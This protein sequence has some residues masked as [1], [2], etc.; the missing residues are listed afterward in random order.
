MNYKYETSLNF[1]ILVTCRYPTNSVPL[2]I[3]FK[4]RQVAV[5]VSTCCHVPYGSGPHL[6]AEISSGAALCLMT[7]NLT[8]RLRW[9]PALP[10]A[11]RLCTSPPS[12]GGLQRCHMSYCSGPHLPT[13]V[14]FDAATCPMAP[15]LASLLRWALT[16]P[17]VLRLPVGC[18]PQ[19]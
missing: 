18:G 7:P 15:D 10:R 12:W 13:K 3:S 11:P 1:I 6:S 4:S 19:A 5:S 14:G 2:H 8:S 9:A 17:H 16:L